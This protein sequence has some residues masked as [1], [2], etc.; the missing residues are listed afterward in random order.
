MKHKLLR[1]SLLS[2]LAIFC[3]GGAIAALMEAGSETLSIKFGADDVTNTGDVLDGKIFSDGAFKLTLTDTQNK[4]AIDGN[5]KKFEVNDNAHQMTHRLK[6][7]AKSSA[8]NKM[9]LTVPSAGTLK[10]YVIPSN[11]S[12]TD[13]NLVLTQSG[14]K[15]FDQIILDGDAAKEAD[16]SYKA[17]TAEVAAGEVEVTYPNGALNFYGFFF[18][19]GT[20]QGGGTEPGGGA[21]PGGGSA[22]E[23]N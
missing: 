13:R 2:L 19:P 8:N 4:M 9:T 20:E 5:N 14:N 16:G 15:L 3:G 6:S 18:T 22:T 23:G 7:G 10:I 12:A 11:S 1:I 21:E 17:V